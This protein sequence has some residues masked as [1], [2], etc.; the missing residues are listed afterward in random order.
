MNKNQ[1]SIKEAVIYAFN[2][3]FSQ[4]WFFIKFVLFILAIGIAMGALPLLALII[5][6]ALLQKAPVVLIYPLIAMCGIGL[7][8]IIEG[9]WYGSVKLLLDYYDN[10]SQPVPMKR[11]FS[12]FKLKTLIN[13]LGYGFIIFPFALGLSSVTGI[14]AKSFMGQ[15]GFISLIYGILLI[16]ATYMIIRL[17]FGSLYI[18]DKNISL[19]DALR[20]SWDITR[21]HFWPLLGITLIAYLLYQVGSSIPLIPQQSIFALIIN[22]GLMF[23]ALMALPVAILIIIYAYRR[24][25]E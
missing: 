7:L 2:S 9:I 20:R 23:L 8:L 12:I 15:F 14:L 21:N 10:G 17:G 25:Q 18:I 24:L 22:V 5:L 4:L 13:L 16:P 3:V 1:L 19:V 6:F 11:F